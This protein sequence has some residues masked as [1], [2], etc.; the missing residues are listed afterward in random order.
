MS[1]PVVGVVLVGHGRSASALL[2]AARGVVGGEALADVVA[3]DAGAGETEPLRDRMCAAL[4]AADQGAG[5]LLIADVYG[6]SPCACGI[7][8]ALG[9]PLVVLSGLSLPVLLKLASLDRAGADAQAIA[10][11]CADSARRAL[12]VHAPKPAAGETSPGGP[13][14]AAPT[15][16]AKD[17]A[18]EPA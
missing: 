10:Q 1:E 4:A 5:V 3:L 17:A 16:A 2:D 13:Q 18:K 15:V 8:Q 7:R 11:A 14:T 12:V 9:R 6:A